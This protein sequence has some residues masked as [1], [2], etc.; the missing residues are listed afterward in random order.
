MLAGRSMRVILAVLVAIACAIGTGPGAF[1]RAPC[2]SDPRIVS[3]CFRVHGRLGVFNGIPI[4]IWIVGTNRVL[5]IRS[6]DRTRNEEDGLPPDALK[7]LE[8]GNAGEFV[9]FGDYEVC[10]LAKEHAGWMRPVC[11]ENALHLHAVRQSPL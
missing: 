9:V 7:L 4:R 8:Q 1:A 5:K 3:T 2:K 6:P 11:V 10:P